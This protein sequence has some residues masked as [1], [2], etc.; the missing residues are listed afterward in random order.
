[1]CD[2]VSIVQVNFSGSESLSP[3]CFARLLSYVEQAQKGEAICP[4]TAGVQVF[5]ELPGEPLSNDSAHSEILKL[6]HQ[7]F[8]EVSALLASIWIT[9]S[10][11]LTV[12]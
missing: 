3:C 5:Q 2:I 1:M 12:S 9:K 6:L 10:N 11:K 4:W 8:E 7:G